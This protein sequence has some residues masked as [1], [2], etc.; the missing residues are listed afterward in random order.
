MFAQY[1]YPL[2]LCQHNCCL[3][4][5]SYLKVFFFHLSNFQMLRVSYYILFFLIIKEPK[6]NCSFYLQVLILIK[7]F[8][9]LLWFIVCLWVG[10]NIGKHLLNSYFVLS[11]LSFLAPYLYFI[12]WVNHSSAKHLDADLASIL[13]NEQAGL[14]S[15]KAA[16]S[17]DYTFLYGLHT[18]LLLRRLFDWF[19]VHIIFPGFLKSFALFICI[20]FPYYPFLF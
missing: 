19:L 14:N 1:L 10:P 18:L 15:L 7:D 2:K 6:V 9:F 4:Y 17:D 12:V 5:N 13:V 20:F 3:S 11:S 16:L 8:T